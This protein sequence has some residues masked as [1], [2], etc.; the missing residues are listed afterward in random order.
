M[1]ISSRLKY[2]CRVVISLLLRDIKTRAG[3]S[4]FGFLVGLALPLG[5]IGVLLFLY[6]ILGRK[7]AIG[8][9]I[10]VFLCSAILPFA[11]WSYTHQRMMTA[12]PHNMPLTSFPVVKIID[13]IAARAIGELLA[14][15]MIV[16]VV[17]SFLLFFDGNVF[18]GDYYLLT[19]SLFLAFFLG[20]STGFL[21]GIITFLVPSTYM[22][23]FIII[24]IFWVTSG[25][26]FIPDAIP[27]QLRF[28][29]QFFALTHIVELTRS[30]IYTSYVTQFS[31]M[32]FVV[33]AIMINIA[34]GFCIM[35]LARA[36]MIK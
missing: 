35:K 16:I 14:G 5:H 13:I 9:D 18:V 31:S 32:K 19:L 15:T 25:V 27:E 11:I 23:A 10:L 12:L 3:S 21:F 30:S 33:S 17:F 24:P 20:I 1:I 8:T 22:I 28:Y 7:P 26:I 2:H 4:Y 6:V 36:Y 34:G 29:L